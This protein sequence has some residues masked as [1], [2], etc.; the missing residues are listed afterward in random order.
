VNAFHGRE[1]VVYASHSL[2]EHACGVARAIRDVCRFDTKWS[3]ELLVNYCS[4]VRFAT[5]QGEKSADLAI[6]LQP[7]LAK[8]GVRS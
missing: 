2:D 4:A 5:T 3:L 6:F 8:V 1:G 7:L